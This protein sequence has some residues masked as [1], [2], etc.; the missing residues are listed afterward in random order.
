MNSSTRSGS[1]IKFQ[2]GRLSD[3]L[4][5]V[6]VPITVIFILAV[7]GMNFLSRITLVSL[8]WIALNAGITVSWIVFLIMDIITKHFGAEAANMLSILAIAANLVTTF[9]CLIISRISN[10]P[11]LDMVVGGQWSILTAS[12]I[13]FILSALANNYS[14]VFIGRRFVKNPD[15]KTAY[16]VRSF[17]S[18]VLSQIVDNFIFLVL[19]FVIFPNIPGAFQ[20]RWTIAQCLGSAVICAIAELLTEIIF[21]PLGYYILGRWKARGVG[22][23]YI[24]KY[25][26]KG[27]MEVLAK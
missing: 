17:V 14:N 21:A 23:A 15:G 24:E 4:K 13:A 18:T 5:A 2:A 27:V 12:T 7:I 19:A 11:D 26:P 8:P 9:V 20:V 16:A 1:R 3:L 10:N 6:P 22:K 25:R